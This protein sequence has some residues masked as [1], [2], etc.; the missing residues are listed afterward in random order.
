MNW[1]YVGEGYWSNM[2]IGGAPYYAGERI[3]I[4]ASDPSEGPT[5]ITLR[6]RDGQAGEVDVTQAYPGS[7]TFTVSTDETSAVVGWSTN[8]PK[9]TWSATR[10]PAP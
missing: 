8:G 2:Q 1:D 10:D 4:S 7:I 5:T 3:T 9:A 6:F